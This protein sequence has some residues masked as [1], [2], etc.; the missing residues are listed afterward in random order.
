MCSIHFFPGEE[1]ANSICHLKLCSAFGHTHSKLTQRYEKSNKTKMRQFSSQ[2]QN[3]NITQNVSI[4]VLAGKRV[5]IARLI[6]SW[7]DGRRVWICTSNQIGPTVQIVIKAF[8]STQDSSC[9]VAYPLNW[10]R[11][12]PVPPPYVVG[13]NRMGGWGG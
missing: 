9:L 3:Q 6:A 5:R 4:V 1:K 8:R 11:A 2:Q 13:R 7:H 12:F 10:T